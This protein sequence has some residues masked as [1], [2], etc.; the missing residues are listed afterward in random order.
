MYKA[1]SATTLVFPKATGS[2]GLEN[3]DLTGVRSVTLMAG[4]QTSPTK[5]LNFELHLDAVDGKLLGTGVMNS[6]KGAPFGLANISFEAITDGKMHTIF[7]VYEGQE[8]I[9]GGL[10]SAQFNAK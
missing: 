3:I 1:A 4:W 9:K 8:T 5:P 6:T 10:V 2:V 7:I